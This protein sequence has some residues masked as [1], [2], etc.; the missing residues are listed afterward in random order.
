MSVLVLVVAFA[1]ATVFEMWAI[2]HGKI[3]ADDWEQAS[4]RR[5]R[6]ELA[7]IEMRRPEHIAGVHETDTP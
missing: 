7:D 4:R 5:I 1:A 6:S 2:R 3:T